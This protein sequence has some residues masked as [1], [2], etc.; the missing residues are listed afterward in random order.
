LRY[1]PDS[2]I[3]IDKSPRARAAAAAAAAAAA[4]PVEADARISL[5][6][7]DTRWRRT[8]LCWFVIV[9]QQTRDERL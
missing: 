2:G 9:L 1:N 6:Y 4:E 5:I 7:I 8:A 3:G